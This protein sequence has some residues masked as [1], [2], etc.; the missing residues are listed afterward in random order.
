MLFQANLFLD[1]KAGTK[2]HLSIVFGLSSKTQWLS[3]LYQL[4]LYQLYSLY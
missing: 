1:K 3:G 2:V 4:I